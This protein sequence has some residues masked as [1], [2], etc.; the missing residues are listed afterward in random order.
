MK[1]EISQILI[2]KVVEMYLNNPF[3]EFNLEN[4]KPIR[5]ITYLGYNDIK[6]IIKENIIFPRVWN[7]SNEDENV[8]QSELE[9][10]N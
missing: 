4:L 7:S 6:N 9:S 8:R 1:K 2:N 3:Q 10:T 5:Q